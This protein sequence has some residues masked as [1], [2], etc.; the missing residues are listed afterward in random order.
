LPIVKQNK[1][2]KN[3]TKL[4]NGLLCHQAQKSH[5]GTAVAQTVSLFSKALLALIKLPLTGPLSV[6]HY[7]YLLLA[8]AVYLSHFYYFSSLSESFMEG[9]FFFLNLC[10]LKS[11]CVVL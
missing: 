2:T 8:L 5:L 10:A 11:W 1:Q 9:I 4:N 6:L 3:P 7:S